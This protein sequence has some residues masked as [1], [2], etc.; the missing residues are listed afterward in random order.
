M[1]VV[2]YGASEDVVQLG[3]VFRMIVVFESWE[4]IDRLSGFDADAGAPLMLLFL[5][6]TRIRALTRRQ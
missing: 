1:I 3:G 4:V 5:S 2:R 6:L